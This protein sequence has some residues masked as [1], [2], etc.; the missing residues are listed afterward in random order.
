MKCFDEF[1]YSMFLDRELS[2]EENQE[3]E[4]HL[5]ECEGCRKLVEH[6]QIENDAIRDGFTND[7]HQ[8]DL[9]DHIMNQILTTRRRNYKWIMP[10]AATFIM[11]F[12]MVLFFLLNRTPVLHQEPRQVIIQSASVEGQQVRPH[13]YN[14]QQDEKVQYIWLEKTQKE[15]LNG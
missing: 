9:A 15:K 6:L 5:K 13:I 10:V 7:T 11:V 4:A 1:Y 14:A 2:H 8:P 3:V 12:S